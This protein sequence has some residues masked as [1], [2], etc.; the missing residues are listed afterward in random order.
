MRLKSSAVILLVIISNILFAQSKRELQ[1]FGD[2]EFENENYGSA[3]Y[4]YKKIIDN[5]G[6]SGNNLTY[7]YEAR[8][9]SPKTKADSTGKQDTSAYAKNAYVVHRLA[10]SYR[11]NHDYL[12]A[13]LWYSRAVNIPH[14]QFPE[15]QFWYG[16]ALMKNE[17]YDEASEQFEQY[18]NSSADETFKKRA[19]KAIVGCYY[20][21][22]PNTTVGGV[23]LNEMDT[24]VNMGTASFGAAFYEGEHSI[25]FAA[26]GPNGTTTNDKDQN[27]NFLSDFYVMNMTIDDTWS[28]PRN[29]DVPINSEHN[30]GGGALSIDRTTFY[31]T[32]KS[33]ASNKDVAIYVSKNFNNRW[34]Q[35]LKLD[36]KVNVEGFKSMHPA[37]SMDGSILYFS[38]DRPG[39]YGGMDIWYCNVDEYGSLSEAVNMGPGINTSG[40]EVTPNYH[41]FTKTLYFSSDGHDGIGGLDV[42]KTSYFEDEGVW[43]T[44]KNIGKPFNSSK[45]DAYFVMSK[46]QTKGFVTTDR[47]TCDCGEDYEGSTFCYKIYEFN[48]PLLEFSISGTVFN[49]ENDEIIPNALVTFKD[50][51]G[52]MDP[53][54]IMTDENGNYE[55]ELVV[56]WELFLKAQKTRFFGDAASITTVGLTESQHFLQDFFLSPIPT[57]EI[58]IPGIEYDFDK[59]T[60]RPKSKE[61]L[62]ELIEFLTINDNIVIE[63]RSHTDKRGNDDYNMTLSEARAKSVVDYLVANGIAKERLVAVGKGETEP[64]YPEASTEEEHQKNRRTAFKTISEEFNNVFKGK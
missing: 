27:S 41:Y 15:V 1:D 38:S 44:P 52:V 49:A 21:Q 3:A 53:F 57:G 6:I 36:N 25:I 28:R 22:D 54:F 13:E 12:L 64:I 10:E 55:R 4:F 29:L 23:N 61:I 19:D 5:S 16:D 63:I 51:R 18:K 62:N 46:D 14:E 24:S 17:K 37:L 58:E 59:A 31:F 30:E 9:W 40:E 32:R 11:L 39:G 47:A 35:P 7:P 20:A 33:G 2:I 48:K 8:S 45:D 60:L 43:S 34:L 42:Y 26:A 50:I 56:G